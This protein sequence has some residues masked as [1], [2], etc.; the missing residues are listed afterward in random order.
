[1]PSTGT[2]AAR[3]NAPTPR[4]ISTDNVGVERRGRAVP[5]IIWYLSLGSVVPQK[6]GYSY[7]V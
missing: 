6:E 7:Y 2:L 4:P 1:M 3:F 5:L